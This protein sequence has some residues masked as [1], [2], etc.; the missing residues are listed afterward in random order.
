MD[1]THYRFLDWQTAKALLTDSGYRVIEEEACGSFP[2]SRFLFQLGDWLN[3]VTLKMFPGLLG[4][5]FVFV[6]EPGQSNEIKQ[7]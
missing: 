5:Q 4:F 2:L 1:R 6:C 7:T 3:R